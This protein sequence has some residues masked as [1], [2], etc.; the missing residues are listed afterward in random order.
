M[1]YLENAGWNYTELLAIWQVEEPYLPIEYV[2]EIQGMA[3]GASMEFDTIAVIQTIAAVYNL[4]GCWGLSAWDA[5]TADGRLIHVRSLD[6]MNRIQDPVTGTY[7]QDNQILIVRNPD[8]GYASLCPEFAG[9]IVSLGGINEQGIAIG[10]LSQWSRDKTFHGINAAFRMRMVMD[11]ASTFKDALVIMNSN[12]TDGWN[13]IISDGAIPCGMV[14]EQTANYV[15]VGDWMNPTESIDPFW[16][17]V[18]VVRRGN[19]YISPVLAA[20]QRELYDPSGVSGFIHFILKKN[21]Y[22]VEW[23]QYKAISD[24]IQNQWGTLTMNSTMTLLRDIYTGKTN[25][26][27]KF[28]QL[29][30]WFAPSHQWVACP[31][32]GEMVIA[33]SKGETLADRNPVHYFKLFELLKEEPP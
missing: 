12:R 8:N 24:E 2:E 6:G 33:F 9:D 11:H 26:V 3:D 30:N 7:L 27:F 31:F 15:Y 21:P 23:S 29:E 28:M 13:F 20:T 1:D 32:T 22:F 16:S 5:A 18:D 10:E 14:V 4:I 17:I 19:L 25:I